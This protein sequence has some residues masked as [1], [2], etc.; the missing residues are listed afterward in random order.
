M[1]ST[2]RRR[3]RRRSRRSTRL[4]LAPPAAVQPGLEEHAGRDLVDHLAAVPAADPPADQGPLG[5]H[6]GEA[7]VGQLEGQAGQQRAQLLQVGPDGPGGRALGPGQGHRAGRRPR[8]SRP[9]RR[10]GRPGRRRPAPGSGAGSW[11]AGWPPSRSGR[12]RRRPA[13]GSRRRGRGRDPSSRGAPR[14]QLDRVGPGDP[15]GLVQLAR[16]AAAGAGQVALAAGAAADRL[17]RPGQDVPGRGPGR[18]PGRW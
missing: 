3:R 10:P 12:T 1:T 9:A 17:G 11:R 8:W 6:G 4:T 18:R 2:P 15:E 13:A 14:E 7:L 5:G 16:V